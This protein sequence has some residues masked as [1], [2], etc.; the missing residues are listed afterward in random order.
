MRS[1]KSAVQLAFH[2]S[3]GL[4]LARFLHRR[5][6][7]ILMYHHFSD[8]SALAAQCAHLRKHYR[9]VSLAEV[10]DCLDAGL[11][12]PPHSL[13]VTVDDGYGDFFHSA[14]PVFSAFRIPVTVFLVTD[15]LDRHSWLWVDQIQYAFARAGVST[16]EIELPGQT[17]R[18]P[19]LSSGQRQQAADQVKEAV[20][21]LSDPDRRALLSRLPD[22]LQTGLP[23]EPP[24][25]FQPLTWDQVRLLARDGIEFGAHTKSHPI[26][27]AIAGQEELREEILG[28]KRRIE[29]ELEKPVAHFCYPNGRARDIH[30][31]AIDCVR[32]AG[33]R[34]AVTA[35]P[36]LNFAGADLF[37][38]R[39]IGVVAPLPELAFRQCAAGFRI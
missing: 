16:L 18:F 32:R 8:P 21:S 27:S 28:S 19:L 14:F 35:E 31:P 30:H 3:G 11:P 29:D 20:K 24:P 2:R 34:T 39:R 12:P 36:G 4:R 33:F 22:L 26:L 13:A 23:A 7:R 37:L 17:L 15:F 5:G 38:L 25:E 1:L 9:L 10:A 6:C